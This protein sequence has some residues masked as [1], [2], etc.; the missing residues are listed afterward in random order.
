MCQTEGLASYVLQ[1]GTFFINGTLQVQ[2]LVEQ[3]FKLTRSIY[4]LWYD[5]NKSF[6]ILGE[7]SHDLRETTTIIAKLT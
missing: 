6:S 2:R 4:E 5:N 1:N 3:W 7:S